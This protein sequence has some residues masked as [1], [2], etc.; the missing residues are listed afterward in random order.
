[1]DVWKALYDTTSLHMG[2]V[3][4]ETNLCTEL[5]C[6]DLYCAYGQYVSQT[7]YI[8]AFI[9][10]PPLYLFCF[11]FSPLH[12]TLLL[13]FS[14]PL[15]SLLPPPS[16]FSPSP[17]LHSLTFLFSPPPHRQSR[18]PHQST[19]DTRYCAL[20]S[21]R[22]PWPA[23]SATSLAKLNG[24]PSVTR[25]LPRQRRIKVERSRVWRHC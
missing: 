5:I 10:A 3:V 18:Y 15:P 4:K 22:T 17:L 25:L 19:S 24:A 9:F 11:Y 6:T 1:M 2:L 8:V 21:T 7:I 13:P 16:L 20:T 12:V 14:P 23:P